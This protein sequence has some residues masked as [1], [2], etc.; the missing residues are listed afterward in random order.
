MSKPTV[1]V[2][3]LG[4]TGV[5]VATRLARSCRVVA[6]TARPALVSGQELGMRLT[7]P[8]VWARHYFVPLSRFRRLDGVDLRHG[9]VSGVDLGASTV[10]IESADGAMSDVPYSALVIASGVSN[11]FWRSDRVEGADALARRVADDAQLL[12]TA[13]V[14]AVVGGGA[15]GVSVAVNQA[16]ST[17]AEVHLFMAGAE[18]LPSHHPA[19]R[20][21]I[22]R[23]LLRHGVV[24]HAGHRAV[25]PGG[26]VPDHITS[27]SIEWLSGQTPFEADAVVWAVGAVR[28]HTG[29]LPGDVLDGDGFVRVDRHLQVPGHPTVFAVG[30]VA[31][32]DP[33]RSSA[34]NWG[35]RVVVG[36]VR[37]VL[38][39]R[40]PRRVFTAPTRR[41]GSVL[42]L[43]PEGLTVVSP[44]GRRFRVPR[45]V[46]EVLLFRLFVDR[47]LYRGIRRGTVPGD[48]GSG[49]GIRPH[50]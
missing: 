33:L 49:S 38:R 12:E 22:T 29:F 3:G 24:V 44:H 15:S 35:H 1:V 8:A 7:S 4:D 30:D 34:R 47:I 18:P 23:A 20:R 5:L 2:A 46:A 32:S 14:V 16:R 11:G 19:V 26:A 39:G 6:V 41:W 9:R 42:G 13:G 37:A 45:R 10:R 17:R 25:L 36:N 27:G 40:H 21:W 43:Q 48:R 31:A 28:P 50:Q